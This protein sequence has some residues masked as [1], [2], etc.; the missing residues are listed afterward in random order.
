MYKSAIR[1]LEP[2]DIPKFCENVRQCDI[3]EIKA[4]CGLSPE[5]VL[6]STLY[7]H[8]LSALLSIDGDM[9]CVFGVTDLL[10]SRGVPWIIATNNIKKYPKSFIKASD[11]IFPLLIEDFEYLENY[12][13]TRNTTSI[14]WLERLGFE[15]MPPE[16]FGVDN[17]PFH[18]FRMDCNV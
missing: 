11:Q 6:N 8:G 16:P 13:D 7:F 17:M 4:S 14:R 12:V 1:E 18:K 2:D 10:D 3:D 9:V 15:I 5:Q